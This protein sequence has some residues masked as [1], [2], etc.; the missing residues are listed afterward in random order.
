[1]TGEIGELYECKNCSFQW[2]D[3]EDV[4]PQCMSDEIGLA[5]EL[6]ELRDTQR[7]T[8]AEDAR[9]LCRTR[10]EK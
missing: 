1:M 6:N 5:W 2:E 4:C 8:E 3:P 10:I 7:R 9:W